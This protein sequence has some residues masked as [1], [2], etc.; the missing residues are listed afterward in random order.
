MLKPSKEALE[1]AA[2]VVSGFQFTTEDRLAGLRSNRIRKIALA[3][4]LDAFAQQAR[5]AALE[6]AAEAI[7][8][9][10][11]VENWQQACAWRI[12]ALKSN[13]ETGC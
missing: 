1:A 11:P 8:I 3:L 5:D 10:S 7:G 2:K 12:R 6:E 4:A 13:G 9:M